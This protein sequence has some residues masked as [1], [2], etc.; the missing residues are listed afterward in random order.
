[1][2]MLLL[3]CWTGFWGLWTISRLAAHTI[4][5]HAHPALDQVV[6]DYVCDRVDTVVLAAIWSAEFSLFLRSGQSIDYRGSLAG[7]SADILLAGKRTAALPD[8]VYRRSDW[9]ARERPTFDRRHRIYVR[10]AYSA[11][12]PIA[13]PVSCDNSAVVTVGDPEFRL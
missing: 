3:A 9:R 11:A 12:D 6:M 8:S 5:C 4:P 1:M 2:L 13:E 10:P 7:E